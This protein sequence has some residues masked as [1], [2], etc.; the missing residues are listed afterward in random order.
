M[1]LQTGHPLVAGDTKA[2]I[3]SSWGL[4]TSEDSIDVRL[5]NMPE[6]T[7]YHHWIIHNF[8]PT[9]VGNISLSQDGGNFVEFEVTGIF[10]HITYLSG[11]EP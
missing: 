5:R 11:D 7:A 8:R 2:T 9:S 4:G 10:T 6:D 3:G 1:V